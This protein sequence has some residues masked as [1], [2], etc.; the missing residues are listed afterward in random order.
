VWNSA[1]SPFRQARTR[2][3][4]YRLALGMLGCL[5]RHTLA[6]VLTATGR[7]HLDWTSDYRF[8]SQARWNPDDL[9]AP[10]VQSVLELVEDSSP[11]VLAIDDTNLKKTG[12]K[13]PGV[14]Y[15]RDPMSPPF[16]P[17]F[18]RAQRFCQ[19]SAMVPDSTMKGAARAVPIRFHHVPTPRKPGR[20]ASDEERRTYRR[21]CRQTSLPLQANQFLAGVQQAL[22]APH[23]GR[24]LI[25][26][27]DGSFCNG[28]FLKGLPDR[29]TVI[30]RVR[31]DVKLH[32]LPINQPSIGRRKVYGE[33]L[34][35][36]REIHLDGSIPWTPVKGF[37]AGSIHTFHAKRVG[38]VLWRKT[39]ADMPLQLIVIKP[40]HYRAPGNQRLSYRHPAYLI[41][42]DPDL[43]LDK[44]I[45]YYLWRWD[46]EVN[47]RDEKQIIGVGQAQVRSPKA[48][49]RVPAFAVAV[50][51]T[52]LLAGIRAQRNGSK[53]DPLPPPKWQR[54]KPRSRIPTQALLNLVRAQIWGEAIDSRPLSFSNFA[55]LPHPKTKQQKHQL[56]L[57]P[58]L[59]YV[60]N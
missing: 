15:R 37:A 22:P 39:G 54:S 32:A 30:G 52:L 58:A 40:L 25:V 31:K 38:P 5:G 53:V 10:V 11:L 46:I 7:H 42:T 35:T 26:T 29:A 59:L 41:C 33:R 12:T 50:Y 8:F 23:A 44:V 60:V 57:A 56:P 4:A 17:N 19:V 28:P 48:V 18:V 49:D 9:F 6:G 2:E 43:P 13:I 16:Q 21:L 1:A 27:V 14:S 55:S 20:S 34:Q 24:Q 47:H 45:Q 36:P 51:A 3:R